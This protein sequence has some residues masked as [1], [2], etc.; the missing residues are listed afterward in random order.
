AAREAGAAPH[1]EAAQ[2]AA[3]LLDLGGRLASGRAGAGQTGRVERAEGLG[4]LVDSL[5]TLERSFEGGF[6]DGRPGRPD[7][8]RALALHL[9][10]GITVEAGESLQGLP[11]LLERDL[12]RVEDL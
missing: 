1:I 9:H 10:V 8:G 4:L 3:A 12:D 2:V 7:R 5:L 6:H 11:A